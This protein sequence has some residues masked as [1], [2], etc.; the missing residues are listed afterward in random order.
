MEFQQS[1]STGKQGND[2]RKIVDNRMLKVSGVK[3][4]AHNA[5][6]SFVFI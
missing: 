6:S 3:H 4:R 2:G 1:G 5:F